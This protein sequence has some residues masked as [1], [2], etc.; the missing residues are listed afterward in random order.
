MALIIESIKVKERKCLKGIIKYTL[1]GF[2]FFLPRLYCFPEQTLI[3]SQFFFY[4]KCFKSVNFETFDNRGTYLQYDCFYNATMCK[5]SNCQSRSMEITFH[6][7]GV[8]KPQH[9]V[10]YSYDHQ[11]R[12]DSSVRSL[13]L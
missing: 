6:F 2:S 5:R 9:P 3:I 11:F 1:K 12:Y 4:V 8:Q 10:R 13:H 7:E